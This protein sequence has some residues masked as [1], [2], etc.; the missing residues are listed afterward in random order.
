MSDDRMSFECTIKLMRMKKRILL[1]IVASAMLGGTVSSTFAMTIMQKNFVPE[2]DLSN[3]S[4]QLSQGRGQDEGSDGRVSFTYA[5]EQSVNSV[6]HVKTYSSQ[7]QQVDPFFEF[8]FGQP[9]PHQRQDQPVP[10]GAGSGVIVAKDGYIVTNNHVIDGAEKVMV[11]LNDKRSFEAKVVG[12]DPNSDIALLKINQTDLPF[13]RIGDSDNLRIG[14]WV[15]AVG[16]PFNLTSTVTAGIVSAKGRNLPVREDMNQY[17]VE[18]FIQTDAVVNPGNSGGALVNTKGELVG[19]N[20][21]I[22]TQNGVFNGYSFAIPA[23]IVKKVV[24]DLMEYG[25]VQRGFLGISMND[26]TSENVSN[27]GLKDLLSGVYVADVTAGGGAAEAG[28]QKGDVVESINGVTVNSMAQV[29]EQVARYRPGDNVDVSLIREG[30]VKHFKVTLR[31]TSSGDNQEATVSGSFT[32]MGATYAN[33]SAQLKSSLRLRGGVQIIGLENGKL[34]SQ[35]VRNGLI[36]LRINRQPVS[37]V[38]DI[39]DV[40]SS[41][42]QYQV[43]TI[44]GIYPNGLQALYRIGI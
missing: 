34:K 39:A 37:S 33:V 22:Y 30:K 11:T 15:I 44:E 42:Q 5:A 35:G 8:F 6:V 16:N 21:A 19:I 32:S 4:S 23:S 28:I 1:A 27:L 26:I 38:D 9:T 40:L 3:L 10:K 20:T 24:H 2:D 36:I 17:Q 25:S 43:I 7:V 41:A 31:K 13:M 29:Q 18:S 14:E 12:S